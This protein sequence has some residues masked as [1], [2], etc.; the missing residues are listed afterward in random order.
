MILKSEVKRFVFN[1]IILI[2]I[3]IL[4]CFQLYGVYTALGADI[5]GIEY[6]KSTNDISNVEKISYMNMIFSNLNS[7]N[8]WFES[9]VYY[10]ST[11]VLMSC[12]PF[13]ITYIQDKKSGFLNNIVSRSS[14]YNYFKSKFIINF[15]SGGLVISSS[16]FITLFILINKFINEFPSGTNRLW[17]E[18]N[19]FMINYLF[20][21]KLLYFSCIFLFLFFIGATYAT[22]ALMLGMYTENIIFSILV[23]QIYWLVGSLLMEKLFSFKFAPWNLIYFN[24]DPI[25]VKTGLIHTTIIF[26]IS[27]IGIVR[28]EER[29]VGKEC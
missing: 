25:H 4:V 20:T 15:I 27:L 7:Y 9:F 6:I 29:R 8:A 26:I 24:L 2:S 19:A 10:I 23:P 5:S 14:K 3:F 21:N 17:V 16:S 18:D 13:S 11:I 22:F 12:L 1:P 28:S